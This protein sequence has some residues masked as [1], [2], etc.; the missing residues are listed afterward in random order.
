M[1]W[2]VTGGAGFIGTNVLQR[3]TKEGHQAVVL[4]NL[5][6][7]GVLDNLQLLQEEFQFDFVSADVRELDSLRKIFDKHPDTDVV[8]HLA[9]QVAVTNSI[10]EPMHDFQVNAAGT[11]NLCEAIRQC[12]P[13]AILLNASTNK[14]YGELS[15]L[16]L[17][18]KKTRYDL[19]NMP[20]G[21]SEREPV[22]FRTPYGCS[23]GTAEQYVRDYART[24]GLRTIS[25]R[26]S[27]IYGPHQFGFEDQGWVAW[28]MIATAL[29]KPIT[30]YGNGKQV[31][32]LLFVNDLVDCYLTAVEQIDQAMGEIYNI[33]GGPTNSCSVLELIGYLETVMGKKI[34][35]SF[36]DWRAGDQRIF[37][38][39]IRKA[40]NDLGW[41]PTTP[42]IDGLGKLS[43]W[44]YDSAAIIRNVL[45]G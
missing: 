22:D 40:M 25:F 30:I 20:Y 8:L 26:Q 3:L 23:K 6:R 35:Y 2:L 16:K 19:V 17:S 29:D 42:V 39:D 38:C 37:V 33:G 5:S 11:F 21:I 15:H 12:A 24:Y 44:V 32:D 28:F 36:E 7:R 1:K 9:A 14:V 45:E 18:E 4:D 31:R 10:M 41:Q 13:N 43:K 27:C 34:R